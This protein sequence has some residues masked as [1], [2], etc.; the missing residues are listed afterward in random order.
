MF[1][2]FYKKMNEV[3]KNEIEEPKKEQKDGKI[4]KYIPRKIDKEEPKEELPDLDIAYKK[5]QDAEVPPP[6]PPTEVDPE[7]TQANTKLNRR[8]SRITPPTPRAT[9]VDPKNEVTP[10]APRATGIDLGNEFPI[11][12][13][14]TEV[15]PSI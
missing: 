13:P 4:S 12:P 15:D 3:I 2:S 5:L 10:P 9:E 7:F 1:Y 14:P 8:K 11:P 6:P